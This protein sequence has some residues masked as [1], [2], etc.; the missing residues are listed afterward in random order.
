MNESEVRDSWL[1]MREKVS[2]DAIARKESQSALLVMA[3]HYQSLRVDEKSIVNLLFIEQLG[4]DDESIRFDA[5]ALI[6]ECS[7]VEALP[8]LRSLSEE[9]EFDTSPG[10]PYEWAK[11]GRL[12]AY[13]EART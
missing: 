8:A 2:A 11:V 3:Q 12:I 5:E 7:I 9:L 6:R 4:A 1:E 13:L 10:A